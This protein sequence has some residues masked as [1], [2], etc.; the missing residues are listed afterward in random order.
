[1]ERHPMKVTRLQIVARGLSNRCPNCGGRTLFREGTL[2]QVNAA[3]PRCG[4]KIERDD[5]FFL[6]NGDSLFDFNWLSLPSF[7]AGKADWVARL[8]IM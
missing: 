4:L 1:M 5:G 3:C 2:F 8:L 6:G 7:D